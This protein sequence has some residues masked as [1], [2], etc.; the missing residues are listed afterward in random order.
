[1]FGYAA[2]PFPGRAVLEGIGAGIEVPEGVAVTFASLRTSRV[3]DGELRITGR[4][5]PDDM[6]DAEA[7]LAE[8]GEFLASRGV[9][10]RGMGRGE[11]LLLFAG[12]A[13]GA[14]T[15]SDPFFE[16]FHPW[17]RVRAVEPAAEALAL[18]MNAVLRAVR[19]VLLRSEVNRAR[20]LRGKPALDVLTTKWSG[21]RRSVPSFA[22]SA[23]VAGAAVTDSR[24][25]RGL[26]GLLGM[27][28]RHLPPRAD[29]AADLAAR[30]DCAQ[31]MIA[32]G[33]RFV[34][35]HTKSTDEAGHT[36]DPLAKLRVLESLDPGLAG[37]ERLAER[38]IVAVTGDHATPSV[39]GVL[40]TG[41]PTPLVLA[42]P[43]V[44]ADDVTEFGE[45]AARHGWYGV[46]RADELLALL[47][48]HANRPMFLGHRMAPHQS[49]ALPD[50]ADPMPLDE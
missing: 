47:F 13:C 1:M 44:R 25:Y 7:L 24:L 11:A 27:A 37:L 43:T 17:L 32:E 8:A 20:A 21:A 35:V 39:D 46:V 36:K 3:A 5:A 33:A 34:H 41:D 19:G 45:R 50:R 4:A 40:H 42:G 6:G 2:I 9:E 12:H 29:L 22:E 15:D 18:E 48:S 14:V 31:A 38:A 23:G 49:L 30:I 10:L 26:A 28:L 16:D